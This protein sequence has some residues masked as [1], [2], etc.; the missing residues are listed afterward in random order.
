MN[1]RVAMEAAVRKRIVGN[2]KMNKKPRKKVEGEDGTF[3]DVEEE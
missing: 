3:Q 2:L 1:G